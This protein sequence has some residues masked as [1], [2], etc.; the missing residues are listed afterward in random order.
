MTQTSQQSIAEAHRRAAEALGSLQ[1]ADGHWRGELQ[2][3][4]ILESEYLLMKFILGQEHEPMADGR[5]GPEVLGRI[6][7]YMRSLQREDGGWG[8]YP[9]SGVDV[10]ATV[11]AYFAL[12][13]M[14]DDPQTPH[15]A[16]ARRAVIANGGA[17]NCNSFTNFYLACLG[18]ISWN[19][20]PEIPPE[21]ILLP[22][23]FYFHLSKVSAWSR[24]MIMPLA[25]VSALRP[26]RRLP[27]HRGID[28]LFIDEH[29]RHRLQNQR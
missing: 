6:A 12:K 15:M 16:R 21:I 13:L 9:G 1:N 10:G 14:G 17:E 29:K 22:K 11:K 3:D 18:Q 2:G 19:A 25:I 23:W 28:E 8:Q 20:V 7:A 4:S 27:A 24:T 26:T 5:S